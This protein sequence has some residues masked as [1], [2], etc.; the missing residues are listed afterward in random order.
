MKDLKSK[1]AYLHG[2]SAGMNISSDS[3]EGRVL[4]GIIEVLGDMAQSFAELENAHVQL[5]D[6]MESMDEDLVS[7]EENIY[8]STDNDLIEVIC[9]ECGE[10]VCFDDDILDDEDVIEVTCPN[11]DEVV[12]I[13][14]EDFQAADEPEQLTGLRVIDDDL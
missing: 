6:Y 4:N 2:L 11:C 5:E 12:F 8:D 1:V 10:T 14:D 3:K 9:P 7:L 13:N